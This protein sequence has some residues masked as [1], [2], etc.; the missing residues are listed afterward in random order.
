MRVKNT[1]LLIGSVAGVLLIALGAVLVWAFFFR[2][3]TLTTPTG[4]KF[5]RVPAGSFLMGSPDDE[6]GRDAD[7]Q[8][9]TVEIT[10]P[11][12]IGA[13]E[14]TQEQFEGVMGFNPSVI[15]GADLP[16]ENVSFD[17]AV[18][19]CRKLSELPAEKS[20]GRS[21]RLP[22]EAEWEYAC[23]AGTK[24]AYGFGNDLT[25][26]QA[27][28]REAWIDWKRKPA[29]QMPSAPKP[30]GS[31]KA[32][33]WGLYDMH[34]N[35]YEWCADWYDRDYYTASPKQDPTGPASGEKRVVRGGSHAS[36]REECRS[37]N[38][39]GLPPQVRLGMG[40]RVVLVQGDKQ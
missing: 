39:M 34:G 29:V 28:T 2:R 30:I 5:V 18:E 4:I 37:A 32:N 10:R 15:R 23:R 26:G 25:A 31:G 21:Y 7:E 19:F 24:T 1:R 20:A 35:V 33:A 14:V 9:H 16:V 36:A 6:P 27:N 11:F 8:Q 12:W 38:R 40:L 3:E 17:E 22:T 13:C